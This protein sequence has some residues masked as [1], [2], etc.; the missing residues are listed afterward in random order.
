M[1]N[2]NLITTFDNGM[3]FCRPKVPRN[4][5]SMHKKFVA[6]ATVSVPDP[7]QGFHNMHFNYLCR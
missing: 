1:I 7:F 6:K 2:N 3:K 5:N 4:D